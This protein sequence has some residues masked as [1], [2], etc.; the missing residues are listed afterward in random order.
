MSWCIQNCCIL[1][2]VPSRMIVSP[3]GGL[4]RSSARPRLGLYYIKGSAQVSAWTLVERIIQLNWPFLIDLFF[5]NYYCFTFGTLDNI[6]STFDSL[7]NL[8]NS[9]EC[10]IKWLSLVRLAFIFLGLG[11]ARSHEPIFLND[12]KIWCG[13]LIVDGLVLRILGHH[14]LQATNYLELLIDFGL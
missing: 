12:W 5:T 9:I 4:C 8:V 14:A 7:K 6:L 10:K 13:I 11:S 3:R 2:W 1:W